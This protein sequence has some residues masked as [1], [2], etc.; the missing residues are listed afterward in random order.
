MPAPLFEPPQFEVDDFYAAL[1]TSCED[2]IVTTTIDGVVTHWN[3]AATRIYGYAAEEMLGRSLGSIAPPDDV[4]EMTE[5]VALVAA[6]VRVES[7]D[8]RR[9]HR[10]GRV[11]DASVTA[12]PIR[13]AAGAVQGLSWVE[14]DVTGRRHVE[15]MITHL[16]F[17]DPLTGLA[18]RTLLDDRLQRSL[19]RTRRSGDFVGVSYLDLD[20]FKDVNDRFGHPMGDRLLQL[21]AS[22][23]QGLLRPDD[24]LA[25][26]GGDEFVV[27]SDRVPSVDAALAIGERLLGALTPPFEL[28]VGRV[29]LTASV[30]VAVGDAQSDVSRL[31][32]SAD[33]AMYSAKSRGGGAV[34]AH[35]VS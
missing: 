18:N 20:H 2:A 12:S 22:R 14:R 34:A 13:D 10:D 19:E 5:T 11:L 21:V 3:A 24:T 23:L 17:H 31:L 35:P 32:G 28:E 4:A 8:A 29:A 27:V 16:A 26:V 33:R 25:R 7:F 30:G 1:V 9:I 6:G 15:R